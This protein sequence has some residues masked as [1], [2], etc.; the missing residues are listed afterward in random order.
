MDSNLKT[1][2]TYEQHFSRYM[3]DTVDV[4]G[5]FQK[6]WFEF[7]L[8]KIRKNAPILEIGSAFGRDADFIRSMGYENL[9]VSDAFDAAVQELRKRKFNHIK[10]INVLTDKIDGSYDL[11][12]AAAVFLHFNKKELT[13]V[14]N[15]LRGNLANDGI[16]A[17]SVKLGDGEEWSTHKM[18]A[19][20]YF[21]YWRE[22]ELAKLLDEN[23][24]TVIDV[25]TTIEKKWLHLTCLEK[26]V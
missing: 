20:R 7:L 24:Y 5:G 26:K 12:V 17:F 2:E 19:P 9:T 25:R 22:S 6:E 3:R 8:T 23:G 13:S 16:L 21:R 4:T 10:K 1:L 18:D 11:I 15:K 14:L